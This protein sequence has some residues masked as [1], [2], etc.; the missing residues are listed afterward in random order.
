MPSSRTRLVRHA[1]F[2]VAAL[3]LAWLPLEDKG[4]LLPLILG[5][6]IAIIFGYWLMTQSS[7][8]PKFGRTIIYSLL[9][10]IMP[11]MV[12]SLLMIFKS[13]LHNHGFPDFPISD[14]FFILNLFPLSIAF[15]FVFGFIY[16]K[17]DKK[18]HKQ[19]GSQ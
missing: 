12:S 9:I 8:K 11:I 3:I 17:L 5:I 19:I 14:L 15:A 16:Q 7:E 4:P 2:L 6:F 10:A 18:N 13:G 1:L